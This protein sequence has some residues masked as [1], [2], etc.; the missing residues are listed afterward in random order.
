MELTRRHAMAGAAALALA[1]VVPVRF[2]EAAAPAAGKQNASFYR[3]KV[4]DAEVT[5]ISDGASTFPLGDGFVLNAKKDEVNAALEEGLPAARQDDDLFR[6]AGHQHRRQAGGDRQTGNG[7]GAVR[8]EQGA[9]GQF[10]ANMAAAGID[11]KM[12]DRW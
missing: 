12:V 6:P 3:Y 2:A 7:P 11:P 5:V 10:A 1:P 8:R 9:V 4:G